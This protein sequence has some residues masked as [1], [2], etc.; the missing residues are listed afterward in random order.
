MGCYDRALI[1][2]RT[3]ARAGL[4]RLHFTDDA[5]YLVQGCLANLLLIKRRRAREQLVE[6][7]AQRVDVAARIDVQAGPSNAGRLLAF[8]LR[9]SR[10]HPLLARFRYLLAVQ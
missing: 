5:A 3:D 1:A 9:R 2:Q 4:W 7:H 8:S 10:F 6:Q